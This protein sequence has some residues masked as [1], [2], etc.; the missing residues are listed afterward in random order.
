MIFKLV[1]LFFVKLVFQF[2]FQLQAVPL[3]GAAISVPPLQSTP[4]LRST[5]IAGDEFLTDEEIFTTKAELV[6]G[7]ANATI[8]DDP[9][10]MGEGSKSNKPLSPLSTCVKL[11][12][13][14]IRSVKV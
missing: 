5:P 14:Q 7:D 13:S 10:M 3:D 11:V 1:Y 8:A 2:F 4:S 12:P 9:T 6:V